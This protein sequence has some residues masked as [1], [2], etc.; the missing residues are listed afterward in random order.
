M[1]YKRIQ[2]IIHLIV[3]FM[4]SPPSISFAKIQ[5]IE[6]CQRI[7]NEIQSGGYPKRGKAFVQYAPEC[8]ATKEGIVLRFKVVANKS[9]EFNSDYYD[10]L[11]NSVSEAS[12][13]GICDST[14]MGA[15]MDLVDLRFDYFVDGETNSRKSVMATQQVCNQKRVKPQVQPAKSANSEEMDLK[16][17]NLA[18]QAAKKQLPQKLDETTIRYDIDCR[19]GSSKKAAIVYRH[20]VLAAGKEDIAKKNLL[21][22]L[23]KSQVV[24]SSCLSETSRNI[25]KAADTVYAFKIGDEIVREILVTEGDCQ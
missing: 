17:C 11:I 24:R 7:A 20:E 15:L 22:P 23:A 25:L 2:P 21:S 18:V 4:L 5:S 9:N 16:T 12:V 1:S 8:V 13:A 6:S 3:A 10:G 14:E 19:Q